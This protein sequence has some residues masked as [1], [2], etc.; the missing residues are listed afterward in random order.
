MKISI[1]RA[2]IIVSVF[3]LA[4]LFAAC[5]SGSA[6]HTQQS[7][8]P[9]VQA[10]LE[11]LQTPQGVD[12]AVFTQLK[13]AFA[14]AMQERGK[15]ASTPP[16][17]AAN[18]PAN[19]HFTDEGGGNY[20]LR[21]EYRN[22]GDY[23]QNGTVGVADITPIAMHFGHA[24]GTDGMDAVIHAGPTGSVGVGDVT[25]IAMNYGVDIA[26]Y[27][28][29]SSSTETGSYSTY[30]MSP[31]SDGVA[32][33]GGWKE[34]AAVSAFDP[35]LWYKVHPED[36]SGNPGQ[37]CAPLQIASIGTPPT[38]TG[39]SPMTGES[40]ASFSPVVTYTGD[41]ATYAYWDF[42][43]GAAPDTVTNISPTTTLGAAGSYSAS[44][45]LTNDSGSDTYYFNLTVTPTAATWSTYQVVTTAGVGD[46]IAIAQVFGKPAFAYIN[47]AYRTIHYVRSNVE[48]P[49]NSSAWVDMLADESAARWYDGNLSL[50]EDQ[51]ETPVIIGWDSVTGHAFFLGSNLTEPSVPAD[52]SISDIAPADEVGSVIL[53]NGAICATIKALDGLHFY[54]PMSYPPSAPGDWANSIIDS[55][56][57][58]GGNSK[59]IWNSEIGYMFVFHYNYSNQALFASRC[60]Y[61]NMLV[62]GLWVTYAASAT[63]GNEA[64]LYFDFGF[65]PAA[66][67]NNLFYIYTSNEPSDTVLNDVLGDE[68]ASDASAFTFSWAASGAGENH[69]RMCSL[70]FGGGDVMAA[71]QGN[72]TTQLI[73]NSAPY[74]TDILPYT[75]TPQVVPSAS[76]SPV[77]DTNMLV[78]GTNLVI[79]YGRED[80]IYFATLPLT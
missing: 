51:Y 62:S 30:V 72:D 50:T 66:L 49:T 20:A 11:A 46:Y 63:S 8:T 69:G 44:V 65:D 31:F 4:A 73:F 10:Q 47:P 16:T 1:F 37:E 74:T 35:A 75:W 48:L 5:T 27:V 61:G 13:D 80:G 77:R 29:T 64:G 52:W 34:F 23:D 43:G 12:P 54:M 7:L 28:V 70:A 45:T 78:M 6:K 24:V 55:T 67:S 3:A 56:P 53:A 42:G 15:I 19:V 18:A 26:H 2:F 59:M 60:T 32:S 22:I 39:V 36:L 21:W 57:G 79:V 71:Y 41:T 25:A 76:S 40:G 33:G 17:G 38:I 58:A 9:D 68:W 14:K